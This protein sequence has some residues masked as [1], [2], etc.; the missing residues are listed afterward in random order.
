MFES[1]LTERKW[2]LAVDAAVHLVNRSPTKI[3]GGYTP[4]ELMWNQ[5]PDI[6]N[7]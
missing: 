3:L 1:G 5:K 2:P 6:S 4:H 7:L